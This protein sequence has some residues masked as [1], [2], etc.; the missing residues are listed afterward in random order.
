MSTVNK[1]T[2]PSLTREGVGDC[3]FSL[4]LYRDGIKLTTSSGL[5]DLVDFVRGWTINENISS[6][7][8]E[9]RF[10]FEDAVGMFGSI[11]GSELIQFKI[12]TSICDRIY[13]FRVHSIEARTRNSS[14]TEQFILNC[15]SDEFIKN[16]VTNVFGNSDNIFNKNT[17]ASKII[18]KLI[19]DKKYI[20]SAKKIL[21]PIGGEETLNPNTFIATNWRPLDTIYWIMQRSIRKGKKGGTLQNGF[22][23]WESAL[24]FHFKSIDG[25]IDDINDQGSVS[26]WDKG[27][28]RIYEYEYAPKNVTDGEPD[29]FSITNLVF[30]DERNWLTGLRHGTWSG[31][32]MGFDPSTLGN[33]KLGLS[34]DLSIDA[35]RYSLKSLWSKMSH[36][37]STRAINPIEKFDQEIKNII[38]YPKRVRYSVL[39]NQIFDKAYKKQPEKNYEHL[40]ELQAYQWLRLESLKSTKLEVSIPG[41]LDLYAGQGINIIIPSTFKVG[42]SRVVDKK[43][44]GRYLIAGVTHSSVG[45]TMKTQLVLL[46]DSMFAL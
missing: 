33:S 7:T 36:L 14:G 42:D 21:N 45:L 17:E 38:D 15:V 23:F 10:Q 44:S 6:A 11:T 3:E 16:E 41:N 5:Y 2:N 37:N 29:Q 46:K 43:F 34:S 28:G 39:P 22:A 18:K 20:G 30:P 4:S 32:S 1:T 26:N 24:G 25:M 35:Y 40:V 12:R 31:F 19:K 27:K 9:A 8:L 13:H